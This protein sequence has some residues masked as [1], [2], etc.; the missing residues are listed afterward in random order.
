MPETETKSDKLARIIDGQVISNQTAVQICVKG[1][2]SGFPVK[3]E[4]IKANYPFGVTY[5]IETSRFTNIS[6]KESFKLVI[7]PKYARGRLSVITRF[8][9][10]KDAG[11][12]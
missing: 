2:V 6:A 10:L 1:I 7:M 5:S 9:F 8:L 3:L 4:A 12:R 11:K